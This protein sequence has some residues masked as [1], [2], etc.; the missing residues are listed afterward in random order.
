MGFHT[1][2]CLDPI[3]RFSVAWLRLFGSRSM[4]L[5]ETALAEAP[6]APASQCSPTASDRSPGN[7]HLGSQLLIFCCA[8]G[9]YPC[10]QGG[11]GGEE[12]FEEDAC[13][14][15]RNSSFFRKKTFMFV[16]PQRAN[17]LGLSFDPY[18]IVSLGFF[19]EAFFPFNPPNF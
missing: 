3:F 18:Q 4:A 7:R 8:P 14:M 11:G 2:I 10:E 6:R 1:S 16:L 19:S 15:L 12:R 5:A 13:S 9:A 17:H